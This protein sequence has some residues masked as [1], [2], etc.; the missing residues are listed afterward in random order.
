MHTSCNDTRYISHQM[1]FELRFHE[2][3]SCVKSL[4]EWVGCSLLTSWAWSLFISQANFDHLPYSFIHHPYRLYLPKMQQL[5]NESIALEREEILARQ[6]NA[7]GVLSVKTPCAAR[8]SFQ[9]VAKFISA[10]LIQGLLWRV[11]DDDTERLNEARNFTIFLQVRYFGKQHEINRIGCISCVR[12]DIHP[13][14][15]GM[16]P[17]CYW[18][19]YQVQRMVHITFCVYYMICQLFK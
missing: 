5:C 1:W 4:G 17:R 2:V 3:E 14:A 11:P 6:K 16:G 13:R 18:D 7:R 15:V 19:G 9:V 8:R 12:S 10:T